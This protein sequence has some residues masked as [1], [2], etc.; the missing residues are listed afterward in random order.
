MQ[1]SKKIGIKDEQTKCQYIQVKIIIQS[2][3][4]HIINY[5]L[6]P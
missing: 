1:K 4:T 2:N 3:K 6:E 5:D